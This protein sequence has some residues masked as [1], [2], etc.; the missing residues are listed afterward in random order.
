LALNRIK[1]RHLQCFVEVARRNS[2]TE[3][4]AV[5]AL[6]QPAVSKTLKELEHEVGGR[7]LNRNRG[8]ATLTELGELFFR[9][10]STSISAIRQ[11][12]EEVARASTRETQPVVVGAMQETLAYLL[13]RAVKL[14][15][16]A[17]PSTGVR[18]IHDSN[19]LLLARLRRG[20]IDFIVGGPME[21]PELEGLSFEALYSDGVNF[22]ARPGHPLALLDAVELSGIIAYPLHIQFAGTTIRR[23]IERFLIASGV[24]IP[25]NYIESHNYPFARSLARMSDTILVSILGAVRED[26]E[27]GFLVELPIDTSPM[28]SPVGMTS[29]PGVPN[30]PLATELMDLVR[31]VAG[32]RHWRDDRAR[33][34]A[35][36]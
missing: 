32:E 26:I 17:H 4:A 11:G 18:I 31:A 8:G 27:T 10:A 14:F 21:S 24:R 28:S 7:L 19:A 12:V 23:T 5:L 16:E 13:P 33:R 2:V 25:A 3:A 15:K 36:E 22:V 9:R 29:D 35:A 20:E 1:M 34:P 6:T 30:S